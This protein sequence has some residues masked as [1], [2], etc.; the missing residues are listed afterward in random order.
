MPLSKCMSI[1]PP[2]KPEIC[3]M[4]F[5]QSFD[6]LSVDP[7]AYVTEKSDLVGKCYLDSLIYL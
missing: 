2:L 5:S 4:F 1:I 7:E 3:V 6:N